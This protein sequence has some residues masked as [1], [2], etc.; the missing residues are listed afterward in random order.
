MIIYPIKNIIMHKNVTLSLISGSQL[1]LS[2]KRRTISIWP[3]SQ[4]AMRAVEPSL[5]CK[6]QSAPASSKRPTA[7]LLPCRTASINAVWPL[8]VDLIFT[9]PSANSRRKVIRSKSSL[10]GTR[11]ASMIDVYP[12]RFC[13]FTS[14]TFVSNSRFTISKLPVD[15]E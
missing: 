5:S 7:S 13:A 4:A 15:T 10:T 1:V 3:C 14:H 8:S 12:A 2:N 6:L 11:A 9:L